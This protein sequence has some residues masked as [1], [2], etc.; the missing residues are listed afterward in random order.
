MS[1]VKLH[2]AKGRAAKAPILVVKP[3]AARVA[4]PSPSEQAIELLAWVARQPRTYAE[5]MAVWQTSCPRHSVWEDALADAL[6][7]VETGSGRSA[8]LAPVTL[9]RRGRAVLAETRTGSPSSGTTPA[10]ESS[11]PTP[12]SRGHPLEEAT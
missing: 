7:E 6:I 8:D 11:R 12:R 4:S 1:A 3:A 5:A 2:A 10:L 9:T